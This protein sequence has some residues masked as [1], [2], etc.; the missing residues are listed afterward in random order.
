M[1]KLNRMSINIRKSIYNNLRYQNNYKKD[2]YDYV[3][4]N[5]FEIDE[6]FK[7]L[8]TL[9]TYENKFL[10]VGSGPGFN[11]LISED[12]FGGNPEGIE[13]NPELVKIS[14]LLHRY[15]IH[16]MDALKF[17][18]YNEY[19]IIYCFKP[20]KN[21][22]LQFE[23]ETKIINDCEKGTFLL[24]MDC[25]NIERHKDIEIISKNIFRKI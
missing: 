20:F 7:E 23:L 2:N 9:I 3:Q 21:L 24:L 12:Y 13:H 1:R 25:D 15:K 10:D 5:F 22:K 6:I 19:N 11:L 17:N 4:Y 18:K 16:E 8:K 14:N